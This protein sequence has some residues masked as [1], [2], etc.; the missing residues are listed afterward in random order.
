MRN[1]RRNF[2][3]HVDIRILQLRKETM[4]VSSP[5]VSV[6]VW[7]IFQLWRR[8]ASRVTGLFLQKPLKTNRPLLFYQTFVIV[9]SG[10]WAHGRSVRSLRSDFAGYRQYDSAPRSIIAIVVFSVFRTHAIVF[11]FDG[12]KRTRARKTRERQS[13][14]RI[15]VNRS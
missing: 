11:V 14:V 3:Q 1:P 2:K 4:F 13:L 12:R 9:S 8:F 7:P 10:F 15:A 6:V 5:G